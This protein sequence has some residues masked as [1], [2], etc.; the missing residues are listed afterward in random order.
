MGSVTVVYIETLNPNDQTRYSFGNVSVSGKKVYGPHFIYVAAYNF[1]NLRIGSK[2]RGYLF[3]QN[4][5][6]D[7]SKSQQNFRR[8]ER[9]K[10]K[11]EL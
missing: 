3:M 11:M 9:E 5:T 10:S 7:K 1:G 2:S 4:Q 6:Q 8:N